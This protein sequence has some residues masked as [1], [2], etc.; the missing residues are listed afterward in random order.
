MFYDT[1]KVD[2]AFFSKHCEER[3]DIP[4]IFPCDKTIC[5]FCEKSI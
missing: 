1:A 5:L 3:L 2:I 4:K